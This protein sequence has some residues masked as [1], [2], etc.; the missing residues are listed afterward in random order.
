M[1]PPSP[2]ALHGPW[3]AQGWPLLQAPCFFND[4]SLTKCLAWP[5][6]VQG[7]P[8]LLACD[9]MAPGSVNWA[10]AFAPPYNSKRVPRK[11]MS[12]ENGNQVRREGRGK[13]VGAGPLQQ[14][15][16]AL[17]QQAHEL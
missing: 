15:A 4:A 11:L 16:R 6:R 14:Q 3:R 8:L 5:S 9:V 12:C 13:G 2:S 10:Q 7:W 1:V 17:Q